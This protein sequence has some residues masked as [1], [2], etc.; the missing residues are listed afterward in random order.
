MDFKNLDK[1]YK[2]TIEEKLGLYGIFECYFKNVIPFLD[3]RLIELEDIILKHESNKPISGIRKR[4]I[5]RYKMKLKFTQHFI[6]NIDK[7]KMEYK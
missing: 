3:K 6:E 1:K 2:E 4:L 7:Y 5:E